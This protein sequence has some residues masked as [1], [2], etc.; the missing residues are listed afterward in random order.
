VRRVL[1]YILPKD[2]TYTASG[3]WHNDLHSENIFVEK[4]HPTQT[5]GMIDWQDVSLN[6]TFLH[7]H[8]PSLIEYE[9]PVLDGF[10]KP[11]LPPDYEELDTDAKK[12]AGA[13]HTA[14]FL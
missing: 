9:G 7:V 10:E 6:P 12:G 5:T 3:L 14:Q 1:P 8:Y 11:L 13:F 4:D 2:D